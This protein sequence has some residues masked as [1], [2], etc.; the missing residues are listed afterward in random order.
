M[1]RS[2]I[3]KEA[4]EKYTAGTE[5]IKDKSEALNILAIHG[6]KCEKAIDS[7]IRE[8]AFEAYRKL[9]K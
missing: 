9:K 7:S 6:E 4:I 1:N 3:E 5:L 8:Q 2:D